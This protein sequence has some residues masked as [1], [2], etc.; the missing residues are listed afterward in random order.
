VTIS[1]KIP[2]NVVKPDRPIFDLALSKAGHA[3]ASAQAIFVTR[4]PFGDAGGNAL[5]CR[6]AAVRHAVCTRRV[7]A[8]SDGPAVVP[9]P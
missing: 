3:A 4:N 8:E 6:R 9:G 7:Y 2:G 5:S 1:T